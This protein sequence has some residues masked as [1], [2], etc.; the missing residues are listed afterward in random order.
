MDRGMQ[1]T[2]F[3]IGIFC[4]TRKR[5]FQLARLIDSIVNNSSHPERVSFHLY[6]DSDDEVTLSFL[7]N[8]KN[9]TSLNIRAVIENHNTRPLSDT[10][11]VLFENSGVDIM[12]QFGDDTIMR[13]SGWDVMIDSAFAQFEDRIALVY[14][15]DGIHNEGFAPHYA[16]HRN[17]IETVGYASP[18]YFTADWSDTWMFEIAKAINRNIFLPDLLIEH[19]H[20]T[21]GKSEIDETTVLAEIR[22]KS[23]DNEGIFRSERMTKEREEAVRKLRSKILKEEK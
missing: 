19:M 7:E 4:P 12:M 11:N 16:L 2:K 5:P 8:V 17:W 9:Y 18:P 15:R 21:Q 1:T 22:R 23:G 13:T 14:G 6:V 10:Y 3:R 20:W